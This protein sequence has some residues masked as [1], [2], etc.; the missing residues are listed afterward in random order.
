MNNED[1]IRYRNKINKN[2]KNKTMKQNEE[3][4]LSSYLKNFIIRSLV[5]I[6]L[7]LSIAILCKNNTTYKDIIYKNIYENNLSF[8][9]FKNFYQ[10]HL[11]GISFLDKVVED[12][13]PVFNEELT[14][15]SISKYY[16]G[17]SLEVEKNYLVPVIESGIVV[18]IG[19]KENYGNVIIIQG[20]DSVDISYSNMKTTSVKLYD[21][22]EKGDLLGEVNGTNLYLVYSKDGNILNYEDYLK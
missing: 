20:M 14:Y 12:V 7:F 18:Y 13:K 22:I 16:D 9:T 15:N 3:N 8:T 19:E 21:Y 10:E 4:V 5:V 17:A 11:G 6:V 2:N 1:I